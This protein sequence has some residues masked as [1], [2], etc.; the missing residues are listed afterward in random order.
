MANIQQKQL[1]CSDTIMGKNTQCEEQRSSSGTSSVTQENC[2]H[3][4]LPLPSWAAQ[5]S[6][7]QK[8][9]DLRFEEVFPFGISPPQS[10]YQ[11]L[12]NKP[13]T[14]TSDTSGRFPIGRSQLLVF[15]ACALSLG[16]S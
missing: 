10:Q 4:E 3:K 6:L 14:G 9:Q 8:T 2:T 15:M 11:P 1:R 16:L 12:V 5:G 7:L 13:N